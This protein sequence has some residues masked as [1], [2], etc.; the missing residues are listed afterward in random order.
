MLRVTPV[1][2]SGARWAGSAWAMIFLDETFL[3]DGFCELLG[4]DLV[5][6]GGWVAWIDKEGP[7]RVY[8]EHLL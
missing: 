6:Q 3:N 5:P 4:Y 7:I 8:R 2:G 1:S